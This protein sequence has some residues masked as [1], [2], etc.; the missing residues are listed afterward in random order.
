M[1]IGFPTE[2]LE[3]RDHS[4]A[5][6][7]GHRRLGSAGERV[8]EPQHAGM[9]P[10]EA[11]A[12][13]WQG[14]TFFG[15]CQ[16]VPAACAIALMPAAI[17][18]GPRGA[19]CAPCR[20]EESSR[21]ACRRASRERARCESAAP[22][23]RGMRRCPLRMRRVP[24]HSSRNVRVLVGRRCARRIVDWPEKGLHQVE[25]MDAHVL[26]GIAA[27]PESSWEWPPAYGG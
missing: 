27:V 19:I 10:G 13:L 15:T 8:V 9:N 25:R 16:I 22:T 3:P 24:R 20:S 4:A 5:L 18:L 1:R 12:I 21:C 23:R 17:G 26:E 2:R 11:A 7:H 6:V 14:A